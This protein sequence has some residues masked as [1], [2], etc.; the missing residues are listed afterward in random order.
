MLNKLWGAM[1]VIGIA[2]AAFQGKIGK[3]RAVG[4]GEKCNHL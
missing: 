4:C 1:I 3:H 2:I